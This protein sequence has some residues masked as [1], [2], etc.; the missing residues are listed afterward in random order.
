MSDLAGAFNSKT[1]DRRDVRLR[2]LDHDHHGTKGKV[3]ME[4]VGHHRFNL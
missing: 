2:N 1:F 4:G 3:K